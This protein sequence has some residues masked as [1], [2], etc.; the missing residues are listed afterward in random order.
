MPD[1]SKLLLTLI[2]MLASSQ[3]SLQILSL[4]VTPRKRWTWQGQIAEVACAGLAPE[5][6]DLLSDVSTLRRAV[7]ELERSSV[8]AKISDDRYALD[9]ATGASVLATLPP[10]IRQ[11]WRQQALII[12]YRAVPWK[13]IES[14]YVFKELTIGINAD[15]V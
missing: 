9:V 1:D 10:E 12:T 2:S 7:N 13:Y 15:T 4:G 3:F 5:L 6:R 8:V 14:A 11:F